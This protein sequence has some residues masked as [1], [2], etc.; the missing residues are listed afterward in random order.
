MILVSERYHVQARISPCKSGK[1]GIN[2]PYIK[3]C[4]V[5]FTLFSTSQD[6]Q[7]CKTEWQMNNEME[8]I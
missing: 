7:Y 3:L 4:V 6:T 1:E 2:H 5:Y 8:R